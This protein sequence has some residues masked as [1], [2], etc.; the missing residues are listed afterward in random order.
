MKLKQLSDSPGSPSKWGQIKVT[1]ILICNFHF[2]IRI[3][4]QSSPK[5]VKDEKHL[6]IAKHIAVIFIPIFSCIFVI[7]FFGIGL[8]QTSLN[9]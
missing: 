5:M 6:R 1:F 4:I 9:K 3:R 2:Y 8:F 7:L